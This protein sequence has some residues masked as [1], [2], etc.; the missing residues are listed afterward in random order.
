MADQKAS[1]PSSEEISAENGNKDIAE[2]VK[3]EPKNENNQEDPELND[4]LNS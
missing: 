4:L 2:S 1:Q 3:V